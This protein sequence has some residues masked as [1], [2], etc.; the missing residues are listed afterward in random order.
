MTKPALLA[1]AQTRFHELAGNLPQIK[2]G[3]DQSRL[4]LYIDCDVVDDR[5]IAA[6]AIQNKDI[7][8]SVAEQPV[9]NVIQDTPEG[10]R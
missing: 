3:Y 4:A 9:K 10:C 7:G 8:Q 5:A 6:M 2:R 1:G